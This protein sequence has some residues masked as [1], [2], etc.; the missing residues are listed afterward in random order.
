[1]KQ[2]IET[3]IDGLLLRKPSTGESLAELDGLR[4][5]A[6]F[7]VIA[8]HTNLWHLRGA[9][10]VGVWL[11][12][13]LSSFLLT[14]IMLAKMPDSLT[15]REMARYLIR[16]IA[17]IL[18]VYYFCLVA[19]ALERGKPVEWVLRH[20]V[21]MQ[22]DDHFWSIPQEEV[23]YL[24]LPFL[25]ASVYLCKRWLRI[26]ATITAGVLMT[27]AIINPPF[28]ALPGNGSMISFYLNVFAVGFFLAHLR[29]LAAIKYLHESRWFLRIANPLGL[30]LLLLLFTAGSKDHLVF[31]N[32]YIPVPGTYLGWEHP[33]WF[34]VCSGLL[35][36][37]TLT[38]G[39]WT[40]RIFVWKGLRIIGV[41]SFSLYLVHHR[42]LSILGGRYAVQDGVPLFMMTFLLSLIIAMLL[43]RYIE[44]PCINHGRIINARIGSTSAN[45]AK[46]EARIS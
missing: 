1:M 13:V 16:R 38:P 33:T 15:G 43:E 41:L 10:A 11:F 35:L 22:A 34:A 5:F 9:G 39:S 2:V 46:S 23:F 36:T 27:V 18:P 19:I 7:L 4:G 21:F 6:V 14:K 40:Q 45:T 8:S 24:M 12:Y 30:L 3:Y 31:Y 29:Q 17:R 28:F 20:F 44:R 25:V 32:L 26:P 37:V 42:I